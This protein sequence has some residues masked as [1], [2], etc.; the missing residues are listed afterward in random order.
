MSKIKYPRYKALAV[1]EELVE[2]LRPCCTRVEI[3]GSIRRGRP[4]V[5][6]VE[7]VYVPSFAPGERVDMFAPPEP[8]NMAEAMIQGWVSSHVIRQRL[9]VEEHPTW[10]LKNKLA[11]HESSGIP[12]DLFSTTE[13]AWF[14]YLVCRTGGA[15]N[16]TVIA[17]MAKSK[18][19]KWNPYAEG[20]SRVD[21]DGKET[22]EKSPRM[23]SEEAVFAFVSLRYLTPSERR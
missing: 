5:G 23:D 20:F 17:A 8:V 2:A 12:V 9:N 7:I 18:G 15:E 11:V 1:A 6:D 14:N 22:G 21:W 13:D 19:W 16:N 4:Q 10:G 3:A